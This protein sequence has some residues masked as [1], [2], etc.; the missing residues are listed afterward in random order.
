MTENI[1]NTA[2]KM[3]ASS[4]VK[5]GGMSRMFC[6]VGGSIAV[7]GGLRLAGLQAAGENSMLEAIANGIGWYCIGKGLFMIAVP[8]NL[9]DAVQIFRH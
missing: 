5:W 8:F 4:E 1:E 7:L 2:A 9:K 6:V 3:P